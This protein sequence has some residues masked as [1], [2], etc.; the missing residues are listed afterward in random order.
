MDYYQHFFVAMSPLS[1]YF[2]DYHRQK[3]WPKL[4]KW[5]INQN[6]P[7]NSCWKHK[8]MTKNRPENVKTKL[9]QSKPSASVKR[10]LDDTPTNSKFK[11]N[12]SATSPVIRQSLTAL[13][14]QRGECFL[15]FLPRSPEVKLFVC[16]ILV[17]SGLTD[18]VVELQRWQEGEKGA[19][20]NAQC[21]RGQGVSARMCHVSEYMQACFSVCACQWSSN[22]ALFSVL[23][24]INCSHLS[25][26]V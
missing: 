23:H 4:W 11:S 16:R 2:G 8:M 12:F 15:L 5:E 6:C 9:P 14:E 18:T 3:W 7:L 20:G 24:V 10:N 26:Q 19:V 25:A 22:P 21:M 1:S 17:A 13:W